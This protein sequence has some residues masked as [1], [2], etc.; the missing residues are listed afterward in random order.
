MKRSIFLLFLMLA[1]V[2]LV[3]Q[4]QAKKVDEWKVLKEETARNPFAHQDH[5]TVDFSV[6]G[7]K[8]WH[9]PLAK[10]K[11][12]SPFGRSR[13]N[14]AGTD[15]KSRPGDTIRAVFPGEVVFSG[16]F[17]AYGNFV[18]IRHL[19]GLETAYSHNSRNLVKVGEWV[20]AGKAVALV[21]ST[22]RVTTPHLH[23]ETRVRGRAFDS[24]KIFNHGARKLKM[25][26]FSF[27]MT[28]GALKIEEVKP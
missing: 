6:Y 27:R 5:F 28:G 20:E 8:D 10:S 21:G 25:Q 1:S 26:K 3:A 9:Y 13:K 18:V 14:H 2:S 19:N 16:P 4:K 7:D 22:G 17:A 11:V 12:I 23:F 24:S 15:I